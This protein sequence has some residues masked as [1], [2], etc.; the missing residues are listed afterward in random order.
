[1]KIRFNIEETIQKEYELDLADSEKVFSRAEEIKNECAEECDIASFYYLCAI[2][3][4]LDEDEINAMLVH[5]ETDTD[6]TSAW[7][8]EEEE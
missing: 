1:M 8:H 2:Q 7:E 6:F 5:E 4:L 3:E